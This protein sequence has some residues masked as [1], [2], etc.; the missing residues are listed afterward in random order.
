MKSS[1]FPDTTRSRRS[2]GPVL[3]GRVDPLARAS[4]DTLHRPDSLGP[5]R[6][7]ELYRAQE[8]IG[9]KEAFTRPE[10]GT[11]HAAKTA[12]LTWASDVGH[13]MESVFEKTVPQLK[14]ICLKEGQRFKSTDRNAD[15]DFDMK[16]GRLSQAITGASRY[17]SELEKRIQYIKSATTETL[18]LDQN[19][20]KKNL[21]N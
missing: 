7:G 10:W 11:R 17:L 19:T 5:G 2:P 3:G 20:L 18:A 8:Q 21:I 16:A 14:A 4:D 13:A 9:R 6:S 15:L 1:L 12:A